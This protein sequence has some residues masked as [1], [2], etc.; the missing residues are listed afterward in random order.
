MAASPQ[1]KTFLWFQSD[2]DSALSFYTKTF[3]DVLVREENRNEAGE[4]FTADFTICGHEF[5][6]MCHTGGPEFN[7]S[8]SISIQC[9]GQQ[10]TDRL[11]SAITAEGAEG[12]CGWCTDKWGVSWQIT[13]LQM[14]DF[15]GHPDQKIAQHNWQALRGMKKIELSQ[16]RS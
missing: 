1:V 12:Q 16:F 9:D 6:A 8:I 11:W 5:I 3:I 2:L 13:P 7:S 14:R 15:L 10:E 4:L